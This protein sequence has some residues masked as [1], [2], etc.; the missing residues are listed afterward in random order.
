MKKGN[1]IMSRKK[2]V[3]KTTVKA[4]ET[5]KFDSKLEAW[6]MKNGGPQTVGSKLGLGAA[7]ISSW[8]ARRRTPSLENAI[9]LVQLSKSNLTF[10]DIL[11]GSR[12]W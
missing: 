3:E 7:T 12:V 2:T 9:N 10:E 11:E 6:V 4:C 1:V 8:L 5:K